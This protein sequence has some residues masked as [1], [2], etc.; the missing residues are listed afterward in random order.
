VEYDVSIHSIP[1]ALLSHFEL[2]SVIRLGQ[3]NL[4]TNGKTAL[5]REFGISGHDH[6]QA[7]VCGQ[8]YQDHA[9]VELDAVDAVEIET[10]LK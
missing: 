10:S 8:F 3:D 5:L 7:A 2:G 6:W 4:I 1:R 9:H